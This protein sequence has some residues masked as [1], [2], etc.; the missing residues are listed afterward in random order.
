MQTV[1][2]KFPPRIRTHDSI[3]NQAGTG[4][5]GR[6]LRERFGIQDVSTTALDNR[7]QEMAQAPLLADQIPT[8]QAHVVTLVSMRGP[9]F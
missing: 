6:V 5:R 3:K 8:M 2:L 4:N 1:V 9:N 7:K